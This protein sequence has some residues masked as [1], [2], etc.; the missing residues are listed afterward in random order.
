MMSENSIRKFDDQH[1]PVVVSAAR[2]ATGKFGGT[3]SGINCPE[4]AAQQAAR[5]FAQNRPLSREFIRIFSGGK[6][7]EAPDFRDDLY[8]SWR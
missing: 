8:R 2:T 5:E 4:L 1:T 3:L 7:G 6:K